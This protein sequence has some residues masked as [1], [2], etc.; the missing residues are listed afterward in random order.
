VTVT[1]EGFTDGTPVTE[2]PPT[3][4]TLPVGDDTYTD[5]LDHPDFPAGTD[6]TGEAA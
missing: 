3:P 1:Q 2:E 6:A 4:I 5:H